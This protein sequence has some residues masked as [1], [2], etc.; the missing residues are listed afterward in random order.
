MRNARA[1]TVW[2]SWRLWLA[3]ALGGTPVYG[4]A[5]GIEDLFSERWFRMEVVVFERLAPTRSGDEQLIFD[6]RD[7]VRRA[8]PA[9]LRSMRLDPGDA[10]RRYPVAPGQWAFCTPPTVT[11]RV[12]PPD[13][14]RFETTAADR[15]PTEPCQDRGLPGT[16]DDAN[17]RP[18]PVPPPVIDPELAVDPLLPLTMKIRGL[19]RTWHDRSFRWLDRN[20]LSLRSQARRLERRPGIEVLFHGAWHQ[21]VPKRD[22]P[23]PILFQELPLGDAGYRVEGTLG[24]TVGRY[25]HFHANL[26]LRAATLGAE[27]VDLV[28]DPTRATSALADPGAIA[29]TFNSRRYVEMD[30]SRRMRSGELNYLDHP[31]LGVLVKID[32]LEAP[33]ALISE[34]DRIQENSKFRRF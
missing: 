6:D 12:T 19:E 31:N 14:D 22:S 11:W 21:P 7:F 18:V 1:S 23:Q 32:A 9:G 30:Q 15:V 29:A 28:F 17:C 16:A 34:F 27:P 4:Q 10:A 3:V 24:V 13:D 26:W 8:Y 5:E 20:E 33:E 25:L 2:S